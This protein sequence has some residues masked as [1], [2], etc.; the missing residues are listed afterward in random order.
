MYPDTS[1]KTQFSQQTNVACCNLTLLCTL[2]NQKQGKAILVSEL[3]F[4]ATPCSFIPSLTLTTITQMTFSF[5]RELKD[6][7]FSRHSSHIIFL[8]YWHATAQITLLW[9]TLS[10]NEI[11]PIT[12]LLVYPEISSDRKIS[13]ALLRTRA[14]LK[15]KQGGGTNI[16]CE[17]LP[18]SSQAANFLFG[19][20]K[21]P[22]IRTFWGC[23]NKNK[24]FKINQPFFDLLSWVLLSTESLF[25]WVVVFEAVVSPGS[26]VLCHSIFCL[27]CLTASWTL[28]SIISSVRT[29]SGEPYALAWN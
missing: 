15:Q 3:H 27:C 24:N 14:F 25:F 26:S 16:F 20:K 22:G 8:D 2:I 23:L 7:S 4:E 21:S 28:S 6:L 12:W 10:W 13:R 17:H 5:P 29:P 1:S 18:T 9:T 11:K 19:G